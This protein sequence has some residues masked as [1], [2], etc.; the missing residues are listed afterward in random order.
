MS[1]ADALAGVLG[2]APELQTSPELAVAASN[3]QDPNGVGRVLAHTVNT[4]AQ[5]RA[6]N[7]V[8]KKVGHPNL[9]HQSLGFLGGALGSVASPV[10]HVAGEAA[11]DVNQAT[12]G[13]AGDIAGGAL[14]IAGMGL[15]EVQH[16][17]R[18]LHDVEA[19]HGPI[20]G[21]LEGLGIAA[22]AAAAVVAAIPTGGTSLAAF[23]GATA[24]I[25]GG[26]ATADVANRVFYQ[27][28][29]DRTQ[30]GEAYQGIYNRD[31]GKYSG[32]PVSLGRD[33]ADHLPHPL[34]FMS[35][36]TDGLADL[37]L[38][39][40]NVVGGSFA[41][42]RKA[43]LGVNTV[44]GLDSALNNPL[45]RGS[46]ER[47]F[48]DIGSINSPTEIIR[49]YPKFEQIARD[50]AN[51]HGADEVTE[52]FRQNLGTAEF[53]SKYSGELPNLPLT[54]V[55]FKA[56]QEFMR[57]YSGP[58]SAV[59]RVFTLLPSDFDKEML[60]YSSSD[61]DPTSQAAAKSIYRVLRFGQSHEVAQDVADA[62]AA[63]DHL[64]TKKD[65]YTNAL[66]ALFKAKGLEPGDKMYDEF[67]QAMENT[68][69]VLGGPEAVFGTDAAGR[70]LS[71]IATDHGDNAVAIF[72]NQKGRWAMP[73]FMELTRASRAQG[74]ITNLLGEADDAFYQHWTQAVF[75]QGAL[76]T[77]GFALRIA[78]AEAI[79]AA[80]REGFLN[81][82]RNSAGLHLGAAA[83]EEEVGN[84]AAAVHAMTRK[85]LHISDEDIDLFSRSTIA[86]GGDKLPA[87]LNADAHGAQGVSFLD[88][89]EGN[90][91][92]LLQR[93]LG[94]VPPSHSYGD[95]FGIIGAG[96]DHADAWQIAQREA[97][98]S[99]LGRK[100]AETLNMQLAAG[101]SLQEATQAST[102]AVRNLLDS[103]SEKWLAGFERHFTSSTEGVEPHEDWGRIVTD[104][105]KGLVGNPHDSEF[106]NRDL[107]AH[108]ADGEAAPLDK[109]QAVAAADQPLVKNRIAK[110]DIP[111]GPI[112]RIAQLGYQHVIDPI[113]NTLSR[114]PLFATELKRQYGPLQN[115]ID[116]GI[117][118][119]DE[120]LRFAQ[121]RAVVNVTPFIHNPL[122][123]S[124]FANLARNFMPF[125]FAQTQAYRRVG[126]LLADDPGAF[127]KFQLSS[128]ALHDLGAVTTDDNGQPQFVYPGGGFLAHA[129]LGALGMLGFQVAGSSPVA[130]SGNIQSLNSVF[131]F[132]E[133]GG[134]VG[135]GPVTAKLG[136]I[137][138]IPMHAV[139]TLFPEVGVPLANKVLGPVGAA[140]GFYDQLIPNTPLRN[141][142]K[143]A[144]ILPSGAKDYQNVTI[145]ITQALAFRQQQAM[146]KWVKAGHQPTDKGHPSIVPLAS[147]SPMVRQR[148]VNRVKNQARILLYLKAGLSAVVP[149]APA[150]TAN[151][152]GLAAEIRTLI[153][154]KGPDGKP[155]GLSGAMTEFL[156]RHPDATPYTVFGSASDT[157][158]AYLPANKPAQDFIDK[159]LDTLSKYPY[160]GVWL[161]PQTSAPYSQEVYQEQLAMALRYKKAPEEF[162][163]DMYI[164]QG[165]NQFYN[166]DLPD[167]K[168][169][170][171][172]V[173][174]DPVATSNLKSQ[175]NTY[176]ETVLGPQNPVWWDDFKS[177][178]REHE[179]TLAV[180]Q[181]QSIFQNGDAPPGPQT[182]AIKGLLE[183]YRDYNAQ[184]IAGRQ[185]SWS[186][187]Q[188]DELKTNWQAY[189]D[190]LAVQKPE[191]APVIFKVFR[192]L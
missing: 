114:E 20:A 106:I 158:G 13:V 159:H 14:H 88:S 125:Y 74:K 51:L 166:Q 117:L 49:K 191:L 60:S 103:K 129:S 116:D 78:A 70:N 183:S 34:R 126:R 173:E 6:V 112:S 16:T 1:G 39:P 146:D 140:G 149:A 19:R 15:T 3:S 102:D 41:E 52:F 69:P 113:I 77:G 135:I 10:V 144:G 121:M 101:R 66:S 63:T 2:T 28:S 90:K 12:G 150:V 97:A 143:A 44:E 30:N 178:D 5:D 107:L 161:V 118:S 71:L 139:E 122:E 180:Q 110:P 192:S 93:A 37:T 56:A 84:I 7:K 61:F 171:A 53:L 48:G 42:A 138:S 99:E 36:I 115:L 67:V 32:G 176:I 45:T 154:S 136:P 100:A 35:G 21:L 8:S 137:V 105:V 98:K 151:D 127:R 169:Q 153:A 147:D 76:L 174:G 189:M 59:A 87:G 124:Q 170:L 27:D 25:L 182:T 148:F 133:D 95:Q 187:Q 92:T 156:A 62:F 57:T 179:R 17:Y 152:L 65:I 188:R 163:K 72:E 9:L 134:G 130:F 164:A 162:V 82:I 108:L 128:S 26:E 11:H 46:L 81:L 111:E 109:L 89:P 141:L 22:G 23:G 83:S 119:E 94:K 47:A 177:A 175:F 168:K 40:L 155:L 86:M 190:S 24:A 43:A 64:P 145:Q 68:T 186:A 131:P 58:G 38:D 54:R 184:K 132:N 104:T 80:F 50:L 79:P 75:K 120:A 31:T 185:D 167:Y 157:A 91:V 160:G 18:A 85:M 142:A 165:N 33:L 4:A 73:D 96:P 123:R 55:P 181:L 172:A 29:W